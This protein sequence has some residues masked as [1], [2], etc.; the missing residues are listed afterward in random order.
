MGDKDK[1]QSSSEGKKRVI[2]KV[3]KG[4]RIQLN[5]GVL[6]KSKGGKKK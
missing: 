3:P 6:P 5:E 4:Q 2:P 1:K